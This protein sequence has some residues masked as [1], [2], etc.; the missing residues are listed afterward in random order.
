MSPLSP[1]VKKQF[2]ARQTQEDETKRPNE[3]ES[4]KI[5]EKVPKEKKKNK[6]LVR[7]GYFLNI[8]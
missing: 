1:D 7:V 2:P 4:N 5:E 8:M 3:S 6:I